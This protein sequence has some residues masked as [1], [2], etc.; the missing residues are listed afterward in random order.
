[1]YPLVQ[2]QGLGGNVLVQHA[3]VEGQALNTHPVG[4]GFFPSGEAM[5][6]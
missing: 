6:Q 3:N 2:G 4:Q 1:M 5:L